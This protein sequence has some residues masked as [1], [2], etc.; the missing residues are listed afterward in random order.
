MTK[1]FD[2]SPSFQA[3]LDL[4]FAGPQEPSGYTERAFTLWRQKAKAI[5][6]EPKSV[7]QQAREAVLSDEAPSRLTTAD[8][9]E[10]E[11]RS[12][13]RQKLLDVFGCGDDQGAELVTRPCRRHQESGAETHTAAAISTRQR[14]G[15]LTETTPGVRCETLSDQRRFVC[16]G[17]SGSP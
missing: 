17:S 12:V 5:E 7:E 4:V 9:V 13:C 16:S 6:G 8:E 15:A 1:H 3:A 11:I 10:G 2:G 14:T